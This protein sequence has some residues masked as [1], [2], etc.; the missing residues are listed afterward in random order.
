MDTVYPPGH[1]FQK[2]Q[3][4][5]DGRLNGP[6]VADMKGGLLIMIESARRFLE[7][8]KLGTIG[9]EILINA[10]EEV[11]STGSHDLLLEAGRW[12]HLGLVFESALPGGKLVRCRK[13]TGTFRITAHGKSAHTGRDFEDGRSA[14]VGLADF[15]QGCHGFNERFPDA[16]LNVANFKSPGPVNVV[17]EHAEAWLNVRIGHPETVTLVKEALEQLIH[18]MESKWPGIRFAMAGD[19]LRSPKLETPEIAL[20][21]TLWNKAEQ[22]LGLPESGKRDTGGTSDGNVLAEAGLPHLDGIGILGGAIHSAEEFAFPDSI[23]VSIDR[24]VRFLHILA[25][26]PD[27]L[28]AVTPA[29]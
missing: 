5:P 29:Q 7:E 24:T 17:P 23:P 13:G 14:I 12:N 18:E 26:Q 6:G 21:H 25:K 8:D 10:D 22:E 3:S 1:A 28:S 15:I 9:G 27:C 20:L 4:L 11:G 16:I 2:L 19:F